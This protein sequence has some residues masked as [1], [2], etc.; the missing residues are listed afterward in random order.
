[1]DETRTEGTLEATR[2]ARNWAIAAHLGPIALSLVSLG[3]LSW[4]VPLVVLLTQRDEHPFAAEHARES[5]NFHLTL[6]LAYL[7][8]LP[9]L[10]FFFCLG[11]PLLG[12]VW[13]AEIVLGVMAA[14]RASD[15]RPYRYPLTLRLF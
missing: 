1:M 7:V 14:V 13:L 4:M 3:I 12:L 15:G 2:E 11:I 6:L 10:I 9:V 8:S 5:L